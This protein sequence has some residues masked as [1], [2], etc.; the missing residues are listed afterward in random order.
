M[1]SMD[2]WRLLKLAIANNG[3]SQ[4]WRNGEEISFLSLVN[5]FMCLPVYVAKIN[6]F[7]ISNSKWATEN[8]KSKCMNEVLCKY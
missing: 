5:K 8:A 6:C 7:I 3:W 4:I 2:R 1:D